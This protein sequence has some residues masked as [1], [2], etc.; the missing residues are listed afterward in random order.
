MADASLAALDTINRI[1]AREDARTQAKINNALTMMQTVSSLETAKTQRYVSEQQLFLAKEDWKRK[2]TIG[3]LEL[4]SAQQQT[5]LNQGGLSFYQNSG[6]SGL[7]G[8]NYDEDADDLGQSDAIKFLVKKRS[9]G[10]WGLKEQEANNIVS[11]VWGYNQ[12][13]FKQSNAIA[14][15]AADLNNSLV[16][17]YSRYMGIDLPTFKN[18]MG[19]RAST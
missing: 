1:L 16:E 19:Q 6:L 8:A 5:A 3:N 17:I 9:D 2:E 10:G 15:L 18:R 7:Y 13:E 11:V 4:L 12:I 14:Q